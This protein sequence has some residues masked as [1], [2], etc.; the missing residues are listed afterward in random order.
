MRKGTMFLSSVA[1]MLAVTD[2]MVSQAVARGGKGILP[3]TLAIPVTHS[4]DLAEITGKEME[5]V[6][7]FKILRIDIAS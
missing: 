7:L 3:I 2:S 1:S 4:L 6:V 5:R